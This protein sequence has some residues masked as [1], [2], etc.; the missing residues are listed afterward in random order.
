[1]NYDVKA[2]FSRVNITPPLGIDISGYYIKRIADGVLDD[3]E[4]NTLA[5]S[6]DGVTVLLMAVDAMGMNKEYIDSMKEYITRKRVFPRRR[7]SF[8]LPIRTPP[9]VLAAAIR[10][11]TK[12]RNIC[13]RYAA[14][15]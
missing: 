12:R 10:S 3:L 13:K 15:A 11:P 7:Y 5:V 2:G 8:I 14:Q 1:M 9:P 4:I 6:K